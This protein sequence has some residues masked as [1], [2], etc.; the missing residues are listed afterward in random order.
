MSWQ[1]ASLSQSS[2]APDPGQAAKRE[3][4]SEDKDSAVERVGDDIITFLCKPMYNLDCF[5]MGIYYFD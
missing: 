3:I 4:G 5:A 1:L 2:D